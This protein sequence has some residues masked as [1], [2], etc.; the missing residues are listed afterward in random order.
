MKGKEFIRK[1]EEHGEDYAMK[2]STQAVARARR[3]MHGKGCGCG[4]C[5][6]HAVSDAN[7]WMDFL[8]KDNTPEDWKFRTELE[9]D[10]LVIRNDREGE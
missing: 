6:K 1:A 10:R 3:E 5:L 8:T 2:K 9:N 7:S 4:N